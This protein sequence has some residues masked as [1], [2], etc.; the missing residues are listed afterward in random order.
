M[1][2]GPFD[3]GD[4]LSPEI[5][6]RYSDGNEDSWNRVGRSTVDCRWGEG[7]VMIYRN[8]NC[9]SIFSPRF[10]LPLELGH[11]PQDVYE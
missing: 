1:P 5:K 10:H 2:I 7:G 3:K 8:Q 9:L 11:L 6:M 4:S